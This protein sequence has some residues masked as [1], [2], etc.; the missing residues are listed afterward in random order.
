M[1]SCRLNDAHM[2]MHALIIPNGLKLAV[3]ALR[4]ISGPDRTG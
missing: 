4:T 3:E 2:S 1:D